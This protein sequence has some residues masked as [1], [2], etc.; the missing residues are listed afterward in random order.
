M[1]TAYLSLGANLGERRK[2]LE[3]ALS[4]LSAED[5]ITVLDVS[6]FYETKAVGVTDQPDFLNI[7]AAVDTALSPLSLLEV[8]QSIEAA[9]GRERKERWGPRTI[10]LDILLYGEEHINLEALTIPHPR[11]TERAFVLVP[12]QEIAPEL[13]IH[14]RKIEEWV[15]EKED[16]SDVVKIT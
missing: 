6:S 15:N 2:Q 9:I 5:E 14:G 7:A 3:R 4:L 13:R 8:T 10:D 12:L 1:T 16:R 11:M